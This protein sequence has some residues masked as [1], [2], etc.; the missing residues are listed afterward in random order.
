M[1]SLYFLHP[2]N[3]IFQVSARMFHAPEEPFQ[4]TAGVVK[5][6]WTSRDLKNKAL[7]G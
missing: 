6:L 7:G 3:L 2:P 1:Y 5:R 4:Y